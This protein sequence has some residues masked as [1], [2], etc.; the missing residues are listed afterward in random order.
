MLRWLTKKPPLG[1]KRIGIDLKVVVLRGDGH[2]TAAQVDDG[3]ITAMVPEWQPARRRI[4]RQTNDLMP[5]ADSQ[6][7]Q[8]Q[9][10]QL[11]RQ[12]NQVGYSF[13]IAGAVGKH[14]A[15]ERQRLQF[16][17]ADGMRHERHT[18]TALGQTTGDMLFVARIDQRHTPQTAAAS[19][20][21]SRWVE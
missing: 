4:R 18:Q 17:Q 13:R 15:V 16:A 2:L 5:Q 21:P 8:T 12:R 14:Q 10:H 9:G 1:G 6:H 11:A 19:P 7:G 20:G 3:M